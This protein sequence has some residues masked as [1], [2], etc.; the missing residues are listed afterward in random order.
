MIRVFLISLVLFIPSLSFAMD[1]N[2]PDYDYSAGYGSDGNRQGKKS[3]SRNFQFKKGEAKK[4]RPHRPDPYFKMIRKKLRRLDPAK[5]D[6]ALKEIKRHIEVM[7]G[8][9]SGERGFPQYNK[10]KRKSASKV[11]IPR[12][13]SKRGNPTVQG[14]ANENDS[15]SINS[16]ESSENSNN[17]KR[18]YKK[19]KRR[20]KVV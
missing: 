4:F 7:S 2:N 20:M 3:K 1:H 10:G 15:K 12:P 13:S 14:E 6:A 18:S 16:D 19:F 11:F 17:E 9:L 5:R 8:I